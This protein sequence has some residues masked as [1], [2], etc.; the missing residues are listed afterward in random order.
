M[1]NGLASTPYDILSPDRLNGRILFLEDVGEKI[2]QVERMLTRLWLAGSLEAAAGLIFGQFTDY[3]PDANFCSM[4]AMI[5][6]R[7]L[8]WGIKYSPT[9][10]D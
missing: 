10:P 7:M 1:L 4:E 8:Q 9:E 5:T 3:Q 2:Y 6:A